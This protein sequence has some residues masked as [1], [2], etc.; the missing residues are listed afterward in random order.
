MHVGLP[1]AFHKCLAIGW[2]MHHLIENLQA[3][4]IAVFFPVGEAV[5]CRVYSGLHSFYARR[6]SCLLT[7]YSPVV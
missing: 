7:D 4:C 1:V 5:Y 3:S 2:A 6:D